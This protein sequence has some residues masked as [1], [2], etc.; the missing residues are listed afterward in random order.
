MWM[1]GRRY[2]QRDP[3]IDPLAGRGDD[4]HP[5]TDVDLPGHGVDS[6]A[7]SAVVKSL[8]ICRLH[9]KAA[10][11]KSYRV[12]EIDGGIHCLDLRCKRANAL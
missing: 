3:L 5:V 2:S 8:L 11:M 4:S 1:V 10:A 9:K 6:G 7:V 12:E